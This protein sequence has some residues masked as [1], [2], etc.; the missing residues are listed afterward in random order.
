VYTAETLKTVH[1]RA[2]L[3]G[4]TA[5]YIG[6]MNAYLSSSLGEPAL[7]Q[8]LHRACCRVLAIMTALWTRS[9]VPTPEWRWLA[10]MVFS[11]GRRVAVDIPTP[12]LSDPAL[13]SRG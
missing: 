10:P 8:R 4:V 1:E 12:M 13:A 5:D 9:S 7:K 3:Q 6:F 11:V 2:G